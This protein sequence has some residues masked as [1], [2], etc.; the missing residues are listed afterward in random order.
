MAIKDDIKNIL[1]NKGNQIHYK[2]IKKL[3]NEY[4]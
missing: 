4:K 1:F 2:N 3:D